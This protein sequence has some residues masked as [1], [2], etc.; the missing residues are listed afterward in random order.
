MSCFRSVRSESRNGNDAY[1]F[2]WIFYCECEDQV[3]CSNMTKPRR[4]APSRVAG[5]SSAILYMGISAYGH[6]CPGPSTY[7]GRR[8]V[9]FKPADAMAPS[10]SV[11]IA[12]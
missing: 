11:R 9:A 12:M 5:K 4:L 3:I 8:I 6:Q 10:H 1:S 7:Q 2:S